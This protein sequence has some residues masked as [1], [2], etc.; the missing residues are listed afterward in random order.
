MH[1]VAGSMAQ[2]VQCSLGTGKGGFTKINKTNHQ[3]SLTRSF[4]RLSN[5][6]S[7]SEIFNQFPFVKTEIRHLPVNNSL[8]LI[9]HYNNLLMSLGCV[10]EGTFLAFRI[11]ADNKFTFL[12]NVI[13]TYTIP[14][15]YRAANTS[16]TTHLSSCTA[17]NNEEIYFN[18]SVITGH[19]N[20]V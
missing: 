2:R 15:W 9:Y 13:Y 17:H 14:D 8:K 16:I 18:L 1:R 12:A 20:Q 10:A 4:I 5:G 3:V 11:F 7:S 6:V 19:V